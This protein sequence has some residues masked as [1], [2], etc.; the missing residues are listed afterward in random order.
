M[1][2]KYTIDTSSVNDFLQ[3]GRVYD[4]EVF[5]SPWKIIDKC[6]TSH[7]IV[8]HKEVYEEIML[9]G[10]PEV[11]K[12]ARSKSAFFED[13]NLP[14]ESD[15]ITKIGAKFPLFLHQKKDVHVHADPWLLAQAHI[16]GLTIITSEKANNQTS[17]PYVARQF[18]I[19]TV[20][21]VGFFKEKKV[22]I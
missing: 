13:Y 2:T 5:E 12:W 10:I 22:K 19:N 15:F 14:E 20:D 17:I 3:R 4:N 21:I 7:E 8:S 1:T 6:C 16:G 9:G 18:G 11:I